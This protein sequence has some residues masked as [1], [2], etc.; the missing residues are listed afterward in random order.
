MK[1]F[2]CFFAVVMLVVCMTVPA[3]GVEIPEGWEAFGYEFLIEGSSTESYI[4]A[5]NIVVETDSEFGLPLGAYFTATENVGLPAGGLVSGDYIILGFLDPITDMSGG[6]PLQV[7]VI[8]INA[9]NDTFYNF[10]DVITI[11]PDGQYMILVQSF[12]TPVIL[13]PSDDNGTGGAPSYD[14]N[15]VDNFRA[16]LTDVL[17]GDDP[18]PVIAQQYINIIAWC[19]VLILLMLPFLLVLFLIRFLGRWR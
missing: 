14:F 19:A 8:D 18:V 11:P 2:F 16:L 12:T 5:N 7:L 9:G 6:E 10:G 17:F 1:R 3:F 4:N 13:K 15:L